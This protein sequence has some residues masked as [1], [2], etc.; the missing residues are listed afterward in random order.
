MTTVAP[1]PTSSHV[2]LKLH[3]TLLEELGRILG[4]HHHN[5]LRSPV[6]CDCRSL[7]AVDGEEVA[8][9]ALVEQESGLQTC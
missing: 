3:R 4:F 8:F 2:F 7:G 1:V 6:G 5:D 9:Q